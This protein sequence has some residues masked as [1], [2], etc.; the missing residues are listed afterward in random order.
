MQIRKTYKEVSPELL[1][2]E[3]RDFVLKQ[4]VSPSISAISLI[5]LGFMGGVLSGFIGYPSI[6]RYSSWRRFCRTSASRETS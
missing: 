1:Y 6:M 2:A 5:M 3:I 4:G